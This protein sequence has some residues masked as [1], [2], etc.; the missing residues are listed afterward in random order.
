M[1]TPS[2]QSKTATQRRR[3]RMDTS[4]MND[5][6]VDIA[7]EEAGVAVVRLRFGTTLQRLDKGAGDFATSADIEAE[8]AMLAVLQRERPYDAIL[9]EE[10]G[11][12][13]VSG[14]A[15]TWL[16]DPLCGTL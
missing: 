12:V 16:L 11:H 8:K 14:G 2:T 3:G 5:V 1:A 10:G 6:N 9:G 7:V 13:G 4:C 15:R